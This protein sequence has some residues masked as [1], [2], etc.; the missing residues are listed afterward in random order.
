[1][2]YGYYPYPGSFSPWGWPAGPTYPMSGGWPAPYPPYGG[3]GQMPVYP[4]G[5]YGQHMPFPPGAVESPFVPPMGQEQ[6][7]EML[8]N[9]ARMLK[10]ELDYIEARLQELDRRS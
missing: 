8:K 2:C 5:G 9:N 3:M 1:M 6:E 7:I 10:E 4:P